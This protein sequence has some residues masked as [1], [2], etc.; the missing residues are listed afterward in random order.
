[1]HNQLQYQ[2]QVSASPVQI[3]KS[4]VVNKLHCHL[5]SSRTTAIYCYL[6]RDDAP[7]IRLPRTAH[8]RFVLYCIVVYHQARTNSWWY[9]LNYC[10]QSTNWNKF[11]C[12][13]F[14]IIAPVGKKF[15]RIYSTWQKK[16]STQQYK[17]CHGDQTE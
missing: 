11:E 9:K 5:I 17:C 7:L 14:I 13:N 16:F 10:E 8:Y 4:S 12:M 15:D 2:R 1:M 3:L 6:L